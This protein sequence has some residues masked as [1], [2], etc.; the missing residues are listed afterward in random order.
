ML[1]REL[2][3]TETDRDK[4]QKIGPSTAGSPCEACVVEALEGVKRPQG[5]YWLGGRVGT[6][7]HMYIESRVELFM[8]DY[9]VPEKSIDVFNIEGYGTVR[10][11]P[12]LIVHP[13][14]GEFFPTDT[15][16]LF[17]WKTTSTEKMPF[18][19]RALSL[20]ATGGEPKA[21]R[22]ARFNLEAYVN[23]GL[24]YAYGC[25]A[26]DV[27]VGEIR[28]QFVSRGGKTDADFL[29]VVFDYNAE[30]AQK[31][32]DRVQSLYDGIERGDVPDRHDDCFVHGV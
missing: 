4:Q 18:L 9:T 16:T 24:L 25:H 26:A 13:N 8:R 29:E 30:R 27:P 21:L 17:D 2:L 12:D 20:P 3:Q 14:N 31:L 5:R 23:Q 15:V 19:R 6:S 11:T 22:S 28:I 10:G 1:L 7:I 32:V